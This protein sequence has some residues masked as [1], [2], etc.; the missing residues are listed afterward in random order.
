MRRTEGPPHL[1]MNRAFSPPF[2]N[3]P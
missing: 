3:T 2:E 1:G